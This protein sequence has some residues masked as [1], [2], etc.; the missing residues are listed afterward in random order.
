M[1]K[2]FKL[3]TVYVIYFLVIGFLFISINFFRNNSIF[4]KIGWL[5]FSFAFL[6]NILCGIF[7]KRI[8]GTFLLEISLSE[9]G[10]V[11]FYLSFLLM[12][13][14]LIVIFGITINVFLNKI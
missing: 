13:L 12:I 1:K 6:F 10:K 7:L 9:Q 4:E 3:K 8:R 14:I 5:F 2:G 11:S